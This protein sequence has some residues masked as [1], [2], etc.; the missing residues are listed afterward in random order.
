MTFVDEH[1]EVHEN[2]EATAG[3]NRSKASFKLDL[4]ETVNADPKMRPRHLALIAAYLGVMQWPRRRA[5]LSTSRARAMTGLAESQISPCR[6]DLVDR[7][8][9]KPD[10][11]Y[12]GASAFVVENPHCEDIRQH[13]AV[14]VEW[15]RERQADRQAKRRQA[16]PVT[17]YSG[18]T[19]EPMSHQESGGMSHHM[20]VAIPPDY[21]PS[22][23]SSEE[24][25]PLT[26][27][28]ASYGDDDD[29]SVPYPVP[30]SEDELVAM[31]AEFG[32]AGISG[33]VVGYFRKQ[34]QE[35]KLTPAMV[36][37]QL[38]AAS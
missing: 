2:L 3:E 10:G 19:E 30:A 24:R 25:D 9:L 29:P 18:E 13:V 7:G 36:H 31:L 33:P 14:T 12:R 21:S 27:S 1:G 8:Y 11:L 37:E 6:K 15:L 34:L 26:G 5:W 28:A 4:I 20:Q 16:Q 32:A 38:R 17:P 23:Y 22:G 35:G